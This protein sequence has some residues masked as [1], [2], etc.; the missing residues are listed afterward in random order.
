MSL[1]FSMFDILSRRV[2]RWRQEI[3]KGQLREF[4]WLADDRWS[5]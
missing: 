1:E 5:G 4:P 2:M 3:Q